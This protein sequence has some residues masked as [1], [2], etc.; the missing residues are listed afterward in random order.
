MT[1]TVTIHY[2]QNITSEKYEEAVIPF[3]VNA[4]SEE[5]AIGKAY[6]QF[7]ISYPEQFIFEIKVQKN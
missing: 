7:E 1:Y 6:R 4:S 2:V 5:E 3:E